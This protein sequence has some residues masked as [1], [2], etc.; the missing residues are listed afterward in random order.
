VL[1]AW[2]SLDQHLILSKTKNR[3][4]VPNQWTLKFYTSSMASV[5]FKM[6]TSRP[7]ALMSNQRKVSQPTRPCRVTKCYR[8]SPA[9]S[10]QKTRIAANMAEILECTLHI[11]LAWP[12]PR[13]QAA[14]YVSTRKNPILSYRHI[15]IV[16]L[17]RR[18]WGGKG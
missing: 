4:V 3:G 8:V 14:V 6:R 9:R 5:R 2:L 10:Q 15:Y 17:Y 7:S 13:G 12:A 11:I 1:L 16:Y 18:D